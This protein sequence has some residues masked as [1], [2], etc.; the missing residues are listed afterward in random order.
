M[1]EQWNNMR[2]WIFDLDGTLYEDT[3]HFDYYASLLKKRLPARVAPRFTEEYERMKKGEHPVRIGK[4]YDV[5]RDCAITLDPLQEKITTV[6]DWSGREWSKNKI[7][8]TYSHPLIFD[9]EN[10]VAIGD[11]WWLPYAAARHFGLTAEDTFFCY[12]ETKAYMVTDDFQLT[13]TPGLKEALHCL[14]QKQ[15]LVLI[16]NSESADVKRLLQTLELEDLFHEIVTSA[17]KPANTKEHFQAMMEKYETAP[18]ETVSVGDNFINEI[19]PALALG[20]NALYIQPSQEAFAHER[21]TV[22][23]SLADWFQQHF[24]F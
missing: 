18:D 20:M 23:P 5:N 2:L 22:T 13:K 17:K 12:Q 4:I 7:N 21:L 24:R 9:F 1:T 6:H 14:R 16:T 10:L 19:A 15:K 11:G 8:A 3:D